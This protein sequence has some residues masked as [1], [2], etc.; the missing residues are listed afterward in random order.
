MRLG[1][2][3]LAFSVAVITAA[4]AWLG[5]PQPM[6]ASPLAAGEK[7]YCLSYA[8]FRGTLTPFDPTTQIPASQIEEDLK[9]LAKL[10]GCVRVYSVDQ[11]LEHVPAERL[12]PAPDCGMKYLPHDVAL[13]KLKAMVAG[14]A[15]VRNELS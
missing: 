8:P 14:A 7:L 10:T 13:G 3:L 1:L 15:I 5:A 6:P 2:A 11:G 12:I 4:W 9:Q